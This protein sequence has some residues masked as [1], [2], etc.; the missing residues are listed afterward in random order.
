ML[1]RLEGKFSNEGII[2]LCDFKVKKL[3]K[4]E[5]VK[6]YSGITKQ[7]MDNLA[8]MKGSFELIKEVASNKAQEQTMIRECIINS[9]FD[10]KELMLNIHLGAKNWAIEVIEKKSITFDV[11]KTEQGYSTTAIFNIEYMDYNGDIKA[12]VFQKPIFVN[13]ETTK[14]ILLVE[15]EIL[16]FTDKEQEVIH[17][18]CSVWNETESMK[19]LNKAE[20]MKQISIQKM[21]KMVQFAN[22]LQK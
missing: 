17:A 11:R 10:N 21:G 19:Y 6:Y 3:G 20:E 9:Q 12:L 2:E 14:Q 4:T 5:S 8:S 18:L 15:S 1:L 7:A 16:E 13:K 22:Y